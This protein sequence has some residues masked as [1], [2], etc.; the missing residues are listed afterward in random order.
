MHPV[1]GNHLYRTN[2]L[3][4]DA[5]G[6]MKSSIQNKGHITGTSR[7]CVNFHTL[8]ARFLL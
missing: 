5:S 8:P 3:D 1:G 2:K 4:R 7:L 6:Q